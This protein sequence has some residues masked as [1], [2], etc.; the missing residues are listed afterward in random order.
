MIHQRIYVSLKNIRNFFNKN[1]E[2]AHPYHGVQNK[3]GLFHLNRNFH[4]KPTPIFPR[5]HHL[6]QRNAL[7]RI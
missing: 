1:L 4:Q 7:K 3:N 2:S 6:S 5:N